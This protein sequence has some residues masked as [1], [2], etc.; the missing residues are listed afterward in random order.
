MDTHHLE[1]Y[2]HTSPDGF[3]KR[4]FQQSPNGLVFLLNFEPRQTLP[5]HTHGQSELVVTVL[6]GEGEAT[7]DGR[8]EPLR[9]G[10]L[11][12]C[13]GNESFSVENTGAGRLSLLV[14]L[15][16]GDPKFA[17]DVR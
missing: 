7:V 10:T 6:A 9:G 11:L 4:V 13:V 15:Y 12:H 2:Q 14:F 1:T 8:K 16:P 3:T 5:S 17:G